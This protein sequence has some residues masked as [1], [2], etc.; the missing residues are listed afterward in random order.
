[1]CIRDSFKLANII[2]IDQ[3]VEYMK[4]AITKSYGKKGDTI[5]NMNYAAVDRGVDGAV[6]V[7]I[8]ASWATAEDAEVAAARKST[9]FVDKV[10]APMNAQEGDKLPVSAFSGREDVYK[11]QKVWGASQG[12][13]ADGFGRADVLLRCH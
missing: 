1:M 12:M 11:R 3:A 8:P 5:L 6:K 2:P 9:E 13:G 4:A 7:E 10:V